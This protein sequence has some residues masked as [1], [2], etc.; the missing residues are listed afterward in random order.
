MSHSSITRRELFRRGGALG[1]L[2]AFPAVLKGAVQSPPAAA[3]AIAG[4]TGANALKLGAD[5]YQ[6]IG[7]RPLINARGT[8]TIIS[9][10][11]MLPEVRGAMDQAAQKYVHLDELSEAVGARLAKLTGAEWGLVSNGCSAGL[12]LATAA[13][14]AGGNPDLH[15]RLPNLS[16]FPKDE[17]IIPTHSRNVYDAALRSIGV[18]VVEVSTIAEFE[19]SL[20]PRTAMIYILAGPNADN[21]PLNVK[22]IAPIA[23]AKGIPIVV[24]AAAEILTIP[25]VHLQNG[26]TLVAYSGGKCIRGPQTAGLLLGRK[27]LVKAAWVH[28]APHH[29]ITRS[30]K[31]GKED[32]IGMLMA[33]E[34]WVKRD[35]EAEWK[36]WTGWL[37]HIGQ[38]VS[39]IAGV[40]T[41]V[42]QPNGLSNRTPSLT[43][44]W[45]RQ[46]IGI[47]GDTVARVLLD[48]DPRITLDAARGGAQGTQTGVRVTPYML[49]AGDEKIIADRLV[50]VLSK[51]PAQTDTNAP[52][53]PMVDVTGQWNVKIQYAA[54][55]SAHTLHLTQKGNDLGGFHQGE[56]MTREITGTIDGDS[57]RIRSAYGE[58]H[59]DSVNLTF[60]GKVSGDQM[61]GPLDM[62]EYLA[63]TWTAT[64]RT[65]ARRG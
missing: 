30:L 52:S 13:C 9:G 62:G 19:A 26:A 35:H 61:S 59:G 20:G 55:T 65:G 12:T 47:S 3:P 60:V 53:A 54:T 43:I 1:S 32:A 24:D 45:D 6:S 8:F 44:L 56:F 48:G 18:R 4:P 39:T 50:A 34:M 29:G 2:L 16:G 7:V 27:D 64:R 58:Q 5:I 31:V 40:T 11:T 23:K 15:V 63:A 10:S 38:R 17:A 37:D 41:N 42:N 21:S 14:V 33:V 49:A 25:N 57:V 51:P 28:S 36:R 22:A 46:K